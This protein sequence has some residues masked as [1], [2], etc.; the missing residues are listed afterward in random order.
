MQFSTPEAAENSPKNIFVYSFLLG[1]AFTCG[2]AFNFMFPSFGPLGNYLAVLSLFHSLEYFITAISNP[3]NVTL[4]GFLFLISAFLLNHSPEYNLSF[5][6]A[7][8]EFTIESFLFPAMKASLS[9]K[10]LGIL[11]IIVGQVSRSLAMIH[12][13]SNFSHQIKESKEDSHQLVK[14]GIYS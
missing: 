7:I 10:Y 12:A 14:T 8:A 6:A 4:D 1:M 11:L 9:S 3:N 13:K 2:V 5:V